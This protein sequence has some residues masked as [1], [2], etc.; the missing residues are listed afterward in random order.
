MSRFITRERD[1]GMG[2]F[3]Y[4]TNRYLVPQMGDFWLPYRMFFC[5]ET[6]QRQEHIKLPE[7]FGKFFLSGSF[8]LLKFDEM[9]RGT[10]AGTNFFVSS[11]KGHRTLLFRRTII[12]LKSFLIR[13]TPVTLSMFCCSG[14]FT[15]SS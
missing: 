2:I 5:S 11:P 14:L 15:T 13:Y 8:F 9:S 12:D 3:R 1:I 7:G 6:S 10:Y 4:R